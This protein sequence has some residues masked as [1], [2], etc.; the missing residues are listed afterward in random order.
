[1]HRVIIMGNVHLIMRNWES[2][3]TLIKGFG[4]A[5]TLEEIFGANAVKHDVISKVLKTHVLVGSALK[6]LKQVISPKVNKT[7]LANQRGGTWSSKQW[8][9]N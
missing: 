5:H 6:L 9:L 1:M 3:C 8:S 7:N 4:L 2:F